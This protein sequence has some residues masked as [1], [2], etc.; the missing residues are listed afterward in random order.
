VEKR[1]VDERIGLEF[2]NT[3]WSDRE[4]SRSTEEE[5][6]STREVDYVDYLGFTKLNDRWGLV[7]QSCKEWEDRDEV[8][9]QTVISA[10]PLAQASRRLRI[11][12]L[13]VLP[14]FLQEFAEEIANAAD[15]IERA[16]EA[17]N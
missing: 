1:L 10:T 5:E 3:Y 12:A 11:K 6:D 4:L 9:H 14:A 7:V 8:F 16:K 13:A 17:L 15:T 2:W